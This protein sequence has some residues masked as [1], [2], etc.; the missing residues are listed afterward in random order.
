M[1]VIGKT[2]TPDAELLHRYAATGDEAAFA[3]VVRRQVNLVYSIALRVANGNTTLAE[4]VTQSVFTDLARKAGPLS[5]HEALAGWLHTSARFAAM[6]TIRGEQRRQAHEKEASAMQIHSTS[7]EFDWEQLR[8]VLDEAVGRLREKDRAAVVLRF[9][10]G[11]SHR[12]VGEALGLNE[13]TA[14]KRVDHALEKLRAHF[15]RAGI[16]VSS[17]L[18]A[19]TLSAHTI[20]AAPSGLADKIIKPSLAAAVGGATLVSALTTI[21]LMSTKTKI[22]ILLF[23]AAAIVAV[24]AVKQS[25]S[26]NQMTDTRTLALSTAATKPFASAY[27]VAA[28]MPPKPAT[29]TTI[30]PAAV[31]APIPTSVVN[32]SD[33][34]A[35]LADMARR[36]RAGDLQGMISSYLPPYVPKEEADEGWGEISRGLAMMPTS[37]MDT[38]EKW[39]AAID[40]LIDQNPVMNS[41]GDHATYTIPQAPGT[42]APADYIVFIKVKGLWY[43][44]QLSIGP[45][46]L[47][48]SL[49]LRNAPPKST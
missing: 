33:L 15:A 2:M 39:P 26:A 29:A 20:Q 12:E 17:T 37:A 10:Q 38:S 13:N 1:G 48:A 28:P 45:Y 36:L 41:Q 11:L 27:A 9:F 6:K 42:S 31:A 7:P 16:T 3:E 40:T 30:P 46:G 32:Q 19:S 34:K 43:I 8:P 21:F 25:S 23:I 4:D 44:E 47:D 35:V 49:P 5:H 14:R 24:I 18:L 22:S